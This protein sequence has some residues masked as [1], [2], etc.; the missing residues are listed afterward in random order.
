MQR[1]N[2]ITLI[3][4]TESDPVF[5][6]EPSRYLAQIEYELCRKNTSIT[7]EKQILGINYNRAAKGLFVLPEQSVI[8]IALRKIAENGLSFT[9]F[10]TFVE[11][12]RKFLIERILGIREIREQSA[13]MGNDVMGNIFH[14]AIETL[15]RPY[16]GKQLTEADI[17][18]MISE[19]PGHLQD[20][21]AINKVVRIDR[22]YNYLVTDLLNDSLIR[23]LKGL[24]AAIKQNYTI[25]DVECNL[26][27]EIELQGKRKVK[28]IGFA[29][30]VEQTNDG[31][32]IMDFKTTH[33][34]PEL[35]INGKKELSDYFVSKHKYLIQVLFYASLY[36]KKQEIKSITGGIYTVFGNKNHIPYLINDGKG[37]TIVL[38]NMLIAEFNRIVESIIEEIFD[39]NQNFDPKP[40]PAVCNY[41]SYNGVL[42]FEQ[43]LNNNED[44][45]E[46]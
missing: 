12:P 15:S 31:V 7:L 23:W 21:V 11:C 24:K 3:Y 30:R 37:E 2:E 25:V 6:K 40:A 29:D 36:L 46:D 32:R 44:E 16:I 20:S 22:G 5:G 33:K 10:F 39:E 38:D 13:E 1:A 26:S 17:D 4:N 34:N 28:L 45:N 19:A 42:C 14:K 43:G 9:G 41:C 27:T 8:D 18:K 35:V